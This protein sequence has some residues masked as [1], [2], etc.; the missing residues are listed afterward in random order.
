MLLF[1]FVFPTQT[2]SGHHQVLVWIRLVSG[3]TL[4]TLYSSWGSGGSLF[5]DQMHRYAPLAYGLD[6]TMLGIDVFSLAL[7]ALQ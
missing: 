4:K 2:F 3:E 5:H 1:E 7:R 6:A